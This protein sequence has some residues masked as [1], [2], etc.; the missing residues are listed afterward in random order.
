MMAIAR[1]LQSAG[2]TRDAWRCLWSSALAWEGIEDRPAFVIFSS[3][4]PFSVAMDSGVFS[5]FAL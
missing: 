1:G 5:P 2:H 4:N 3:D